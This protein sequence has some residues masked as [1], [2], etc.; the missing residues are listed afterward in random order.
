MY[1][2]SWEAYHT[3]CQFSFFMMHALSM[4]YHTKLLDWIRFFL[5]AL[6]RGGEHSGE[7]EKKIMRQKIKLEIIASKEDDK[8]N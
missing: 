5:S 3:A 1:F 8:F 4:T 2:V 7:A 6:L